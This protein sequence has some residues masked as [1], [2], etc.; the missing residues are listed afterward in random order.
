[1]DVGDGCCGS[2]EP[3]ISS[4]IACFDGDEIIFGVL[5]ARKSTQTHAKSC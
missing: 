2:G 5:D 1:M 3:T 4:D